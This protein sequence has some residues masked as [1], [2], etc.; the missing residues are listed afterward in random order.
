VLLIECIKK[1]AGW[2][3]HDNGKPSFFLKCYKFLRIEGIEFPDEF[4]YF[5]ESDLNKF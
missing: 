3:A 5:N 2:F 1:W 4:K